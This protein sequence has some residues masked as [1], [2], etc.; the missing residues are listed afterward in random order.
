MNKI[1]ELYKLIASDFD[2][3]PLVNHSQFNHV[4]GS[5]RRIPATSHKTLIRELE[6]YGLINLIGKGNRTIQFKTK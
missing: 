5:K 2:D 4:L 1:P 3:T 6:N